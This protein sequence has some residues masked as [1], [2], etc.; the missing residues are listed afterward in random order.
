MNSQ[1][2]RDRIPGILVW[3]HPSSLMLVHRYSK[4]GVGNQHKCIFVYLSCS[5]SYGCVLNCIVDI[6]LQ[7]LYI[8][9]SIMQRPIS[10]F[11][12]SNWISSALGN[13]KYDWRT[14]NPSAWSQDSNPFS[15]TARSCSR[16]LWLAV[17]A[18]CCATLNVYC[19]TASRNI[20]SA[21]GFY[22]YT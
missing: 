4:I 9:P 19:C 20:S 14:Q 16:D 18:L 12:A 15:Q 1:N 7:N 6:G 17:G 10:S 11:I 2:K 22:R 8:P 5:H 13:R 3:C 21:I